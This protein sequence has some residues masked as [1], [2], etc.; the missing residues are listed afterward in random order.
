MKMKKIILLTFTLLLTACQKEDAAFS[1]P[2]SSSYWQVICVKIEPN[3]QACYGPG[4]SENVK[5]K[6]ENYDFYEISIEK[7][8]PNGDSTVIHSNRFK[9]SEVNETVIDRNAQNVVE[10]DKNKNNIIFHIKNPPY[11]YKL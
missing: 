9:I 11:I 5:R 1:V 10:I 6:I 7:V 4:W 3:Y 8:K 2:E